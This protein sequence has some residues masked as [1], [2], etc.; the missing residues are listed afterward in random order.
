MSA[1][2]GFASRLGTLTD[3]AGALSMPTSEDELDLSEVSEN[4][5]VVCF[6]LNSARSQTTAAQIGALALLDVQSMV[7][8]RIAHGQT[9]RPVLV[10]VDEFSAL[11]ADHVV[12]LFARARS[13]RVAMMLATQELSDLTRVRTGFCEQ[14][15]GLTN[16]KLIMR[17][18]VGESADQLARLIGTTGSTKYTKQTNSGSLLSAKTGMGSERAVEE[19]IVHPNTFKRLRCGE[20]VL[21]RKDPFRVHE[22]KVTP[23]APG[24]EE[25][26]T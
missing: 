24:L 1:L 4:G 20:A 11:D 16:T 15:L 22:L 21:L 12:S 18:E 8:E 6:S 13:S 3:M 23:F 5:G 10:C 14:I 26:P 2:T 7:A 9:D 19:F 25:E 17:Q